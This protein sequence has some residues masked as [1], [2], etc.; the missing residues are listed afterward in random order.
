MARYDEYATQAEL[1]RCFWCGANENALR[2]VGGWLVDVSPRTEEQ[3]P[4]IACS[5][6]LSC[7]LGNLHNPLAAPAHQSLASIP[8][9]TVTEHMRRYRE[10]HRPPEP[11]Q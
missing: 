4:F 8:P 1:D 11:S 5:T 3:E 9:L 10:A 6:C 2:V 7:G